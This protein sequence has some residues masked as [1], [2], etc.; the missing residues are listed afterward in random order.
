[1]KKII[2]TNKWLKNLTF[3]FTPFLSSHYAPSHPI[4]LGSF[5]SFSLRSLPL[6]SPLDLGCECKVREVTSEPGTSIRRAEVIGAWKRWVRPGTWDNFPF[7]SRT[8]SSCLTHVGPFLFFPRPFTPSSVSRRDG[9]VRRDVTE[10][11]G[12]ASDT[13]PRDGGRPACLV[14]RRSSPGSFPRP[15]FTPVHFSSPG[16]LVPRAGKKG[17]SWTFLDWR[18]NSENDSPVHGQ[19]SYIICY[20]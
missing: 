6:L 14:S 19:P 3:H 10:E 4:S 20:P 12:P 16:G 9:G 17:E 13:V 5:R 15:S 8:G 11:N 2:N 7:S 18:L 1:M